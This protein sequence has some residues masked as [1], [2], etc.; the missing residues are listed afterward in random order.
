MMA[1]EAEQRFIQAWRYAAPE[2]EKIR[3]RELLELD[4]SAGLRMIGAPAPS[5]RPESGLIAFQAWMMRMRV[6]QL[7]KQLSQQQTPSQTGE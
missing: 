7:T 3:R 4:E 5:E 2:L 1:T 6:L